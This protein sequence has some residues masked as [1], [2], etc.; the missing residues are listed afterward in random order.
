MTSTKNN[1]DYALNM[2]IVLSWIPIFPVPATSTSRSPT[3]TRPSTTHSPRTS[4]RTSPPTPPFLAPPTHSSSSRLII[5]HQRATPANLPSNLLKPTATTPLTSNPLSR[6][7]L[8]KEISITSLPAIRRWLGTWARAPFM[9]CLEFHNTPSILAKTMSDC[10]L[11][12][13]IE[14]SQDTVNLP[15]W[16]LLPLNPP[17]IPKVPSSLTAT[18]KGCKTRRRSRMCTFLKRVSRLLSLPKSN[19]R[20]KPGWK[21]LQFRLTTK[22]YRLLLIASS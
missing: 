12:L 16:T 2:I 19:K 17:R 5:L 18:A 3:A 7:L 20:R 21:K 14:D 13:P 11:I 22:L 9:I 1:P 8:P 10:L 6:L 15:T 4:H